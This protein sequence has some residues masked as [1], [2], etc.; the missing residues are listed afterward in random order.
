VKHTTI[1]IH[2]GQ[3]PPV[4]IYLERGV[5]FGC[6][7]INFVSFRQNI[8]GH[9]CRTTD[10]WKHGGRQGQSVNFKQTARVALNM[11]SLVTITAT[12]VAFNA[13]NFTPLMEARKLKDALTL[14]YNYVDN[15][16]LFPSS[17][18]Y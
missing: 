4:I 8:G 6:K 7:S 9:Y 12:N 15:K 16:F 18:S 2:L 1:A 11:T 14:N 5:Y 17:Q 3:N 10:H 13:T